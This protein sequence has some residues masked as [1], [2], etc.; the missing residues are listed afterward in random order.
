MLWEE[1]FIGRL[2]IGGS[3]SLF[4]SH[5]E[6]KVKLNKKDINLIY[7]LRHMD[8]HVYFTIGQSPPSPPWHW[9]HKSMLFWRWHNRICSLITYQYQSRRKES[10]TDDPALDQ[11]SISLEAAL[12]HETP[13]SAGTSAG[14]A[15]ELLDDDEEL[16]EVDEDAADASGLF[17]CEGPER[18][19]PRRN[20][21]SERWIF[22]GV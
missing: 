12:P 4:V 22:D 17:G 5:S 3:T 9:G 15:E 2:S 1:P 6:N 13:W 11:K 21:E 20:G 18:E 10:I 14:D 8:Q 16:D 7:L 19:T